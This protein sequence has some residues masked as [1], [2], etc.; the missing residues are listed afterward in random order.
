M[1]LGAVLYMSQERKWYK[2]T[3]A[4]FILLLLAMFL[5]I[6]FLAKGSVSATLLLMLLFP[7]GLIIL[8]SKVFTS[9]SFVDKFLYFFSVLW[10]SFAFYLVYKI[11]NNKAK[12]WKFII[13]LILL[14]VI[15]FIGCTQVDLG[16]SL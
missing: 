10:Y 5:V 11:R 14:Y 9:I 6:L 3:F 4:T 13:I 8:L 16:G 12:I 1:V 7:T 2:G 15:T